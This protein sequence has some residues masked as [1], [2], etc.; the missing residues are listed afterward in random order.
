MR[1]KK[2]PCLW[3]IWSMVD[4]HWWFRPLLIFISNFIFRLIDI[5]HIVPSNKTNCGLIHFRS[6][7]CIHADHVCSAFNQMEQIFYWKMTTASMLYKWIDCIV[8]VS[9]NQFISR[10]FWWTNKQ[11]FGIISTLVWIWASWCKFYLHL[12]NIRK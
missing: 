8:R 5:I 12:I 10:L 7:Q 4:G 2:I 11:F 1:E 6:L 3:M 9:E